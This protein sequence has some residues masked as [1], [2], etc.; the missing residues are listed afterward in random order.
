MTKAWLILLMLISILGC[1]TPASTVKPSDEGGDTVSQGRLYFPATGHTVQPPFLAYYLNHQGFTKFGYPITEAIEHEGWQVQYFQFVRL[2]QHPENNPD[3][4]I[5]VGWLGQLSQRTQP[6]TYKP[7]PD[8]G[9]YFAETGHSLS[10]TF[11]TY[12]VEN[13]GTVQFGLPISEPFIYQGRVA[14]DF[15]S[16]RFFWYPDSPVQVQREP[17]GENYF[18]SSDLPLSLLQPIE[19][20][21]DDSIV[22]SS[23]ITAVNGLEA[24]LRIE[25]TARQQVVRVIATIYQNQLPLADYVAL[26]ALGNNR[27]QLPPSRASGQT[28]T[29]V[30]LASRQQMRFTLYETSGQSILAATSYA[31]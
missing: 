13:G 18:L 28:H 6:P 9:R 25:P 15:Q 27:R 3:Y 20:W 24:Q 2:E 29:L 26:L 12:F 22:Q 23:S 1:S 21:P 7:K 30:D 10:G 16:A 5:T 17:L 4:F 14:Q 11:L 31:R 19:P 8:Q